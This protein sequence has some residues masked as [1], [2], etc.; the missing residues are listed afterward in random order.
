MDPNDTSNKADK[1]LMDEVLHQRNT[2]ERC[3]AEDRGM[4]E[5]IDYT[6]AAS[7]CNSILKNC[8]VAI[9]YMCLRIKFL[10]LSNQLNEAESFVEEVIK[11]PELPYNSHLYSWRARVKIYCGR[12]VVGERLL[13]EVLG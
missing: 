11:R 5:D 9:N 12:D 7:Y 3:G 8:P 4:Q 1:N 6:K 10:L 2:I 13:R